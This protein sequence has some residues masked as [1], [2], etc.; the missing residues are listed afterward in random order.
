M[1]GPTGTGVLWM[2]EP[3]IEPLLLG[4]GGVE[5]V[6]GTEFV[7][8]E[9]YQRYEAGTANIAGGIGLGV[10]VDYLQAIG[11]DRIRRHEQAL[12]TRIIEGLRR[13]SRVHLYVAEPADRRVG[14]ISFTVDG[15]H[16]HEVAQRLDE[17]ADIMVRSGHHCCIP[18]MERLGL[19]GRH[20]PGQHRAVQHSRRG[21]PVPC[22][23]GRDRQVVP[24]Q[25]LLPAGTHTGQ[26]P[27]IMIYNT[28][29]RSS[30][31]QMGWFNSQYE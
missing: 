24:F 15:F 3:L 6:K 25:F 30:V 29:L 5:T 1:L 2:K 11:M 22:D 8:S 4:G 28:G 31:P 13:M 18:L 17:M 12:A 7:L 27:C 16:P 26:R 20:G 21:G 19:P 10:A 9:G 23:N 14:V